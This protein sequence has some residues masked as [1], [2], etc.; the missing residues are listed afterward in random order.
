MMSVESKFHLFNDAAEF[1]RTMCFGGVADYE[2]RLAEKVITQGQR[3]FIPEDVRIVDFDKS[4]EDA[5]L[6]LFHLPY[7][8]IAVLSDTKLLDAQGSTWTISCCIQDELD[9]S[10]ALVALTKCPRSMTN[11]GNMW[12]LS[13]LA[14]ISAHGGRVG[15]QS[16][17][18]PYS[19]AME[20]G[21]QLAQMNEELG[22]NVTDVS[23][24]LALLQLQN[25]KTECISAPPKLNAK[26]LRNGKLPLY[27]YHVLNVGGDSWSGTEGYGRGNGTRSHL[28]R[29]HIRR[30]NDDRCVW[31]RATY[32]HGRIPGFVD[33][34]YSAGAK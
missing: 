29:G 6:D 33:K 23:N 13:V 26:R 22:T 34:D 11:V 2:A 20:E 32:V 19:D 31:V 12:G 25:V 15:I 24:L 5:G 7:S 21:G 27:E 17:K 30:M 8:A 3:F 1:M 14:N 18:T 4:Q 10:Y 16:L 9:G 28:R